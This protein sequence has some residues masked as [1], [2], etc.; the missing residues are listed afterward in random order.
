MAS[1]LSYQNISIDSNRGC[2]QQCLRFGQEQHASSIPFPSLNVQNDTRTRPEM[3]SIEDFLASE[4]T[5]LSVQE[6]SKVL[7]DLHCVGEELK[8]TPEMI[9]ESLAEFD[10][11]LQERNE[12]IY[13]LA[14]SQNRSYV[15]DPSFRLRFLRANL[16]DVHKSVNQ[17]IGF[18]SRKEK[19]F[20]RDK[21]ARDVTLDD[22][23]EDDIELLLSGLYHIQDG[24]D[25]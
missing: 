15:E 19:Y 10:Q 12:P 13:H 24:T 22:L 2:F 16:H 9:E 23:D 3:K 5:K 4:M 14:T 17:M 8:E 25:R 6:R 20:G 11:V 7:D 1:S 21:V 18:L